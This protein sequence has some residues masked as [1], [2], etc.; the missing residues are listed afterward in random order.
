[1]ANPSLAVAGPEGANDSD[2]CG[3]RLKAQ[4]LTWKLRMKLRLRIP[5]NAI[6]ES[7]AYGS[8]LILPE[9]FVE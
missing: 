6:A 7:I 5:L 4:S 9:Q 3:K 1:M 2:Q 8:R